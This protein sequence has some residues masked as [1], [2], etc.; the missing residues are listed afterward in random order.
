MAGAPSQSLHLGHKALF[1]AQST[2]AQ[3]CGAPGRT[4]CEG[5]GWGCQHFRK[6]QPRYHG[7][8]PPPPRLKFQC[9]QCSPLT[10]L[11]GDEKLMFDLH[12]IAVLGDHSPCPSA[13]AVRLP[14]QLP[15]AVEQCPHHR[16]SGP[17]CRLV[18]GICCHAGAHM[19]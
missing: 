14:G 10:G 16:T 13:G 8:R 1:P 18:W 12:V 3:G 9:G 17:S 15:P 6:I 19:P 2:A 7:N 5:V 4:A 11:M